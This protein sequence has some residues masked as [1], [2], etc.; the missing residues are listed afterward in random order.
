MKELF[1]LQGTALKRS[2][3]YH[4]QTDGQSEVVNKR[5]ESYL[6]CFASEQPRGWAK[7]LAW[8]ELSYNTA[9]HSAT[10]VS[11][12][13]VVYGREQPPI[14]RFSQG[15]TTVGSIEEILQ[16]R[17][18][19]LEELRVTLIR[20]QQHM[21]EVEIRKR[22]E[23]NFEEGDM[24]Y[25]KLQPYR[26]K[27]LARRPFEKLAA[28]FYGPF[29][30]LRKVGKVAYKL[31]LPAECKLHP[32]FHVSQLKLAL[33]TNFTPL[34]VPAQ[35]TPD[36]EMAVEPEELKAVRTISKQGEEVLEVL[37]KWKGLSD[38]EATWEE[39]RMITLRFHPSTLRTSLGGSIATHPPPAPVLCTYVRR[40]AKQ[41]IKETE[42][43]ATTER[44]EARNHLP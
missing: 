1:R 38:F 5:L 8:A 27:S 30:V 7:W 23:V 39:A 25:L 36:L 33:G 6:R 17:D 3:A 13:K 16:E 12:F 35:L 42:A 37:L 22:R 24:V 29:K 2:T 10:K 41:G 9:P 11:P 19:M 32:F 14:I 15:D 44:A 40:Q 20:S 4:P 21:K 18:L 28:R 26:Q 43:A 31:Q 34:S